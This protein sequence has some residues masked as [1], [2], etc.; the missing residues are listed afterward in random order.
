MVAR[1]TS[2]FMHWKRYALKSSGM[3]FSQPGNFL[4][5]K[6]WNAESACE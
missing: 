1:D 5:W 6:S 2:S 4:S 3:Q